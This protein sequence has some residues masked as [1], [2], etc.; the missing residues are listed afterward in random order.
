MKE[1]LLNLISA[2]NNQFGKVP[3]VASNGMLMLWNPDTTQVGEE[4]QDALDALNWQANFRDGDRQFDPRL[5]FSPKPTVESVA[6]RALKALE[7]A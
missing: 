7:Q 2:I 6:D 1:K 5:T 3:S 4:I